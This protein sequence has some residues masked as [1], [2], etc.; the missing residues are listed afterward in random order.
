MMKIII[1]LVYLL[2]MIIFWFL[3]L[4]DRRPMYIHRE[5]GDGHHLVQKHF[6]NNKLFFILESTKTGGIISVEHS[7]FIK[8][9]KRN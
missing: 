3:Y 2:A 1:I 6:Y 8:N 4:Y 5:T 9:F 7:E